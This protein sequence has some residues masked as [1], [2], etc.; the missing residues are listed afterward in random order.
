M[1]HIVATLGFDKI[2]FEEH[3]PCCGDVCLDVLI[4]EAPL[5]EE[6]NEGQVV[7]GVGVGLLQSMGKMTMNQTRACHQVV[8]Q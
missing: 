3:P 4:S 2:L 5:H 7:D 1:P 8:T 6:V